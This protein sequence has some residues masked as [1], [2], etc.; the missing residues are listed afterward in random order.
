MAKRKD[1]G[2]PSAESLSIDTAQQNLG[3]NIADVA[4]LAASCEAY[5]ASLGGK[6]APVIN[7]LTGN[8][9][10]FLAFAQGWRTKMRDKALRARI[11]TDGHVP[12]MWRVL[13]VRN[14][15]GWYAAFAAKPGQKLFLDPDKRV[16]VL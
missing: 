16:K 4:G 10:F 14:L 1:L 13:T 7:G 11:A 12:A 8:Q 6:S 2:W 3:E 15:D 5:H 9:R